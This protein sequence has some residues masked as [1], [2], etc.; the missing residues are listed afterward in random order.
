MSGHV[1]LIGKRNAYSVFAEKLERTRMLGRPRCNF[2][3]GIKEIG[4]GM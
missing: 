1:E 4:W 2:K 3:M